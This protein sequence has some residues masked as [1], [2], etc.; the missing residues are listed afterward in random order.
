MEMMDGQRERQSGS[1]LEGPVRPGRGKSDRGLF[2]GDLGREWGRPYRE[3]TRRMVAR[4]A[5]WVEGMC[6]LSTDDP[7]SCLAMEMQL[8]E[9]RKVGDVSG[10][11]V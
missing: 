9:Q 11:M 4:Q 6:E 3:G 10:G 2:F 7:P 5:R 8:F 1:Q